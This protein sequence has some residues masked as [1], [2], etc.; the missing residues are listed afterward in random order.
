MVNPMGQHHRLKCSASVHMRNTSSRG[1]SNVRWMKSS[2]SLLVSGF[3]GPVLSDDSFARAARPG[4][5]RGELSARVS[6]LLGLGSPRHAAVATG[7]GLA[8]LR[9]RCLQLRKVHFEVVEAAVPEAPIL[10]GP[11]GDFPE[12]G[13]VE[14]ARS[15]LRLATLDDESRVGEHPQVPRDGRS[16]DGERRRQLLDGRLPMRKSFEDLAPRGVGQGSKGGAERVGVHA[17]LSRKTEQ[18][19]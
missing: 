9:L 1:A 15:P 4:A 7:S 12:G 13:G 10:L 6:S 19:A 18:L 16:A 11:F 17:E 3:M 8:W 14:L 5:S 2:V